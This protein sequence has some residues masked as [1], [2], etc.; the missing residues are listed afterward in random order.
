MKT[1]RNL[2]RKSGIFV[3]SRRGNL[4]LD[5]IFIV[6]GI[7]VLA[8]VSIFSY[9]LYKEFND[10]VQADTGIST[11]AK[12]LSADVETKYPKVFDQMFALVV[13]ML[14]I[15]LIVTTYLIDTNPVFF[16]IVFIMLVVVFV[17]GMEL[18]NYYEEFSESD[19][20]ST[21]AAEF[22]L[23]NWI[24]N[25]LLYIIIAMVITGA[26]ALYAKQE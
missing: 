7:F 8:I 12:E 20:L 19:D 16:V 2:K 21:S 13:V 14:W 5:S 18:S 22:P 10:G 17:V 15:A 11:E 26:I 9:Q 3:S 6:I 4:G 25:H 24:M 23:T 1:T